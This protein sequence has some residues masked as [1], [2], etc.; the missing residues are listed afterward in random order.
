MTAIGFV[1][2]GAMGSQIPARL[3]EGHQLYGTNR[4]PARSMS[5]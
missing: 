4:T 3:L 2:L 5:T 1:G